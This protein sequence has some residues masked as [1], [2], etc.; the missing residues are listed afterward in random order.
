MKH[1][2]DLVKK[3]IRDTM[4]GLAQLLNKLSGGKINPDWVTIFGFVMHVPIAVLIAR[5]SFSWAAVLLLIFGLF[6]TLDGELARLQ[7]VLAR[8][9]CY[10][11]LQ[12]IA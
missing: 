1:I 3:S 10:W 2:V 6:D 11:M 12:L 7:T 8:G 4:H 5:G 9:E